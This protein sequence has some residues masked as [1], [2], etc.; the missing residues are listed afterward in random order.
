MDQEE[1]WLKKFAVI[2]VV[3]GLLGVQ[4]LKPFASIP[5]DHTPNQL[6]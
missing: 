5:L 3:F 2:E 6:S 4:V 1:I